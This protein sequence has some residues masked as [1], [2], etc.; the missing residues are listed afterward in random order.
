MM[1]TVKYFGAV[2]D[3]TKKKEEQLA[4]NAALN[5]LNSIQKTLEEQ[6]PEL[7]NINYRFA[8]NQSIPSEDVALND[9]DEIALLPP[10]AGG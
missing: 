9:Q 2:T 6:Y 8:V 7:R 3:I 5:S 4:L 10:F 1:V